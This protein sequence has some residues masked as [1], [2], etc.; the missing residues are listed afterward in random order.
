VGKLDRA[1]IHHQHC[2]GLP[3]ACAGLESAADRHTLRW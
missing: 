1:N 3:A 2:S